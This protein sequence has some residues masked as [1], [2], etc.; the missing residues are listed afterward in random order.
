VAL[1]FGEQG[2]EH[3]RAGHFIAAGILDVENRALHDALEAGG[4]FRVLAILDHQGDELFIDIFLERLLQRLD[5]D[6]A[7]FQ[8]L[9]RIALFGEREEK[10]FQSRGFVVPVAR[11][12]DGAV[13]TLFQTA[14]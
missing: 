12:F 3:I 11:E 9:L 13:Q 6:I 4:G 1:A 2:D 5:I 8:N 14:G 7:G 10:V